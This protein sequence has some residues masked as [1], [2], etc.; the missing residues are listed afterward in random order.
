MYNGK[1]IIYNFIKFYLFGTMEPN[2]QDNAIQ[3]MK[4]DIVMNFKKISK[5]TSLI[6]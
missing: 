5:N 1:Q 2:K 4:A 6:N 3:K